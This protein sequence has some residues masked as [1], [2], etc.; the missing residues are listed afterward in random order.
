MPSACVRLQGESEQ[1]RDTLQ[2]SDVF[3]LASVSE[4]ICNAVLEAMACGLP[5]VTTDCGGMREAVSDCVEGFV[6]PIRDSQAM[7]LALQ[8]LAE[9][10]SL[11]KRMGHAGRQ[12]I[13][14]EFTLER[15]VQQFV[16]L[17]DWVR[18]Q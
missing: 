4:G 3:M 1:V 14:Q 10:S 15:Q 17:Y 6:V 13:L 5:V 11:Q 9:D 18:R 12:R 16:A 2:Q 8:N 7:A